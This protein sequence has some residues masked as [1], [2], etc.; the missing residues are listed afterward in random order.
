TMRGLARSIFLS[1]AKLLVSC[2]L[3]WAQDQDAWVRPIQDLISAGKIAEARA[4]LSALDAPR[5]GSYAAMLLGARLLSAEN[6]Y[7]DS[8]HMLQR[9]LAVRQDDPEVYK[10]VALGALRLEKFETAEEALKSAK[11]FL[12]DDYMV[13]FN[14]GALYYTTSRFQEALPELE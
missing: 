13:H 6:R 3:V 1:C 9:C 12:P 8:L 4:M 10:L 11:R 5:A 7:L 2:A 14:L